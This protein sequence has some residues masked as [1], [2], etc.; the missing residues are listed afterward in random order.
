[1]NIPAIVDEE[2]FILV[3]KRRDANKA[4]ALRYQHNKYLLSTRI[5]CE[6]C[7]HKMN[8]TVGTKKVADKVY[9]YHYYRCNATWAYDQYTKKCDH[10]GYY[11]AE[12]LDN[13]IWEWVKS[14]LTT[15]ALLEAG[16]ESYL[17]QSQ[18]LIAP[19]RERFAVIH[20]I[21]N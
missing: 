7:G 16:L 20:L 13:I 12:E 4:N 8:A 14:F 9:R 1:M 15:P 6:R 10:K 19:Q 3:Q 17:E 18:E 11:R 5:T 21:A 2:A